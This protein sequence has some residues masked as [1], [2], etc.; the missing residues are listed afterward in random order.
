MISIEK[1]FA[2]TEST[3]SDNTLDAKMYQ[4]SNGI[5]LKFDQDFAYLKLL[6]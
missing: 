2:K 6:R 4:T 1:A 5:Q 3:N